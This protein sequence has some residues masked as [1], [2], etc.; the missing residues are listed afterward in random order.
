MAEALCFLQISFAL[1]AGPFRQLALNGHAREICNV[2]DCLLL[3]RARAAWLAIIHGKRSD[4]LI[5][6]RQGHRRIALPRARI[7]Y[8]VSRP[9]NRLWPPSR[10][11]YSRRPTA[12]LASS[13]G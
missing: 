11:L 3:A 9:V 10:E 8:R 13:A 2:L 6:L 4:P 7:A 12:L 1:A 5:K